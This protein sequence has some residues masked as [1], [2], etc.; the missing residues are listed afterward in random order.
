M[1]YPTYCAGW[2]YVVGVETMRA[3]LE[4]AD[5][6][7]GYFWIDDVFVTGVLRPSKSTVYE[8]ATAFLN[9][10]VQHQHDVTEGT[11]FSPELMAASDLTAAQIRHVF[12]KFRRSHEKGIPQKAIYDDAIMLENL[13]PPIV[14]D[15]L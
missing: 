8:W 7:E 3:V 2:A 6:R 13:R 10:H 9:I 12:K 14:K 11:G 15:E 1:E 4:A 5:A